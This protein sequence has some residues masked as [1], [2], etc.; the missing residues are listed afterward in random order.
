MRTCNFLCS[1]SLGL[2]LWTSRANQGHLAFSWRVSEWVWRRNV[3]EL[4]EKKS[5]EVKIHPWQGLCINN[6]FFVMLLEW[7]RERQKGK[8]AIVIVR[9]SPMIIFFCFVV[10]LV[11]FVERRRA[12]E[13][14]RNGSKW[15]RLLTGKIAKGGGMEEE[16]GIMFV[17]VCT[18]L[19]YF[20]GGREE[21]TRKIIKKEKLGLV[22]CGMQIFH[23]GKARIPSPVTNA[24]A[25]IM[26]I[27]I[28]IK[29]ESSCAYTHPE[30][31]F[32]MFLSITIII[33]YF[34]SALC[35]GF[36]M[37][38]LKIPKLWVMSSFDMICAVGGEIGSKV[39]KKVEEV[40]I[41]WS[42]FL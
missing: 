25:I 1:Q 13:K 30:N 19:V 3:N 42:G 7:E 41:K 37:I 40:N 9:L 24:S 16:E 33:I 10:C 29:R 22:S 8:K 20:E 4:E 18:H 15:L 5:L 34:S 35:S 17:C 11:I 28:V 32:L 38:K 39:E 36:W 6:F 14:R 2:S 31:I 23:G 27:I 12:R 21:V 26:S